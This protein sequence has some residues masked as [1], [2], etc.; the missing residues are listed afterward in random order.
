MMFLDCPAY[1]DQKGAVRCGLPAEVRARF[2][3]RSTDGPVESAMIRCPA[4]HYFCAAIESLTWDGK[5]KQTRARPQGH[6]APGAT[7]SQA[8][9]MAVMVWAGSPSGISRPGHSRVSPAPT[10]LRPTTWATLPACGSPSCAR[11]AGTPHPSTR[12]KPSPA[13]GKQ[14]PSR[15]GD[16]LT[17]ARAEAAR[18]PPATTSW[19]ATR[20]Q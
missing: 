10:P 9:M 12:S 17:G 14:I 18:T 4:G 13:A 11:A 6:P 8:V 2:T 20:T 3:M 15:Q 1:L 5:D 19:P 16:P 7:A